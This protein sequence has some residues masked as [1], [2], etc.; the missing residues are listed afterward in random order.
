[1]KHFF[2]TRIRVVLIVAVL[3]AAILA[4]ISGVT[5]ISLPNMFVQGVLTPIRTGMSKLTGGLNI[6]GLL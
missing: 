2:S 6:P 4:V 1:M 3:L 5:G